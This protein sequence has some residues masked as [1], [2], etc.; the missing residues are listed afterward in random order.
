MAPK[1]WKK[2][3]ARGGK[4]AD[5]GQ[6][7][8]FFSAEQE[9]KLRN[10]RASGEVWWIHAVSVGESGIAMKLIRELRKRRP[11]LGFFVTTTTPTGLRQFEDFAK[12]CEGRVI[13]MY[14]ALDGWFAVRRF[15]K[16]VQPAQL[17]LVE[18]EVWPNLVLACHGRGIPVS[19]VNARLSP[20]SERR[21]RKVRFLVEPIYELLDH[22]GVQEAEDPQR[23]ASALGIRPQCIVHTGS[24]KFDTAGEK[25][26]V[27]QVAAFRALLSGMA[28]TADR[29]ILLAASTHP[30]EELALAKMYQRLRKDV[31]AVY[32]V[33][34]PRHAERGGEIAKEL[35]GIGL[36]VRLRSTLGGEAAVSSGDVLVVNSTGE[37]RAWQYLASV[38]VIGKSFLGMGGQNPAEAIVAGKPVIF[39]PHMENFSALRDLLLQHQGALEV[40]DVDAAEAEIRALMQ[41]TGKGRQLAQAGRKALLPHAGATARTADVLLG[42]K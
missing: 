39:G 26:P 33:V 32:Y 24:I 4:A 8:G 34:V 15:L 18:A 7:F 5:L 35:E 27:E 17:I 41:S 10:F 36:Q 16:H 40:A 37:L 1:A 2:M 23:F 12:K 3:K 22:V 20:R 42:R 11:D 21:F 38:V 29:P 19:L 31:P 25:E 6:R 30:G 28:V 13:P 14:S 9:Q